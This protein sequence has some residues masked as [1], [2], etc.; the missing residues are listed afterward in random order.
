M[1]GLWLAK[2][3]LVLA[4]ESMAR[5]ALLKAAGIPFDVIAAEIDERSVEAPL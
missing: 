1:S 5:Q 2:T 3:P 4:S